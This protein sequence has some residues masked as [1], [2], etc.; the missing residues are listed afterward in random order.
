M[1]TTRKGR[2]DSMCDRMANVASV[3]MTAQHKRV[4]GRVRSKVTA[5]REK[6]LIA[7]GI[8]GGMPVACWLWLWRANLQRSR[9]WAGQGRHL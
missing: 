8:R 2:K 6:N 3:K 9:R 7:G 1:R 4:S 5:G